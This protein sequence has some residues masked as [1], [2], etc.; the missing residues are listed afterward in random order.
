MTIVWFSFN[1]CAT[2][3]WKWRLTTCVKF[4]PTYDVCLHN[5]LYLHWIVEFLWRTNLCKRLIT[6]NQKSGVEPFKV[7]TWS[8]L[9]ALGEY[10]KIMCWR[11]RNLQKHVCLSKIMKHLH[12][13]TYWLVDSKN[14]S[15][16]G[17][18]RKANEK[19]FSIRSITRM[20][21]LIPCFDQNNFIYRKTPWEETCWLSPM[22]CW[23][24]KHIRVENQLLFLSSNIFISGER[25]TALS[26]RSVKKRAENTTCENS[27]T[28]IF[29][30][31]HV[32]EHRNFVIW[33]MCWLKRI[34]FLS[35][36]Q[37]RWINRAKH[38]SWLASLCSN[39]WLNIVQ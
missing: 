35:S 10:S 30:N 37:S 25:W 2:V 31:Y 5:E 4:V 27:Q 3:Y 12:V 13:L 24:I 11:P 18:K 20:Q 29:I 6:R 26:T 39:I 15:W 8:W 33:L 34:F 36:S 22:R 28:F 23:I 19:I 38:W 16:C 21:I 1:V 9:E 32:F 7:I 17:W 14:I